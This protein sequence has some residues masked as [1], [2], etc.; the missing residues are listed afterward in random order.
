[1]AVL[2]IPWSDA[3][4]VVDGDRTYSFRQLREEAQAISIEAPMPL[5]ATNTIDSV[6]AI[7]AALE[8][9]VPIVMIHPRL[10]APERAALP[11]PGHLDREV[12]AVLY[13]SGTSGT[14]KGAI[15]TRDAF[16]AAA[17]ASEQVLGWREDDRWLLCMPLAHVGGLSIVIRCLLAR[18]PFVLGTVRELAKATIASLVPTQL[19][20]LLDDPAWRPPASLRLVLLGG[21]AA[22]DSLLAR[23]RDRGVPVRTTYGLT[24]ACSQV[25]TDGVPLPGTSVR[26]EDGEIQVCG[27][28]MMR[29]YL[30][31]PPLTGWFA[32]GDLGEFVD[33][34]L[35]VHA[36][37]SDLIVTGGE[38]VYPAEVE[39]ILES[40]PGVR[41]ALVYGIPDDTWGQ[42]VA[43]QIVGDAPDDAA[44]AANL[45]PHKRPRV[46]EIVS[47]IRT[48]PSGKKLRPR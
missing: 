44:L 32:T 33:G 48:T 24:E 26:I 43:A 19:A 42:I 38:N 16:G 45:A 1:V 23:A 20:R 2:T 41:A 6:I 11:R 31:E 40:L 10:T 25:A 8:R 29:G 46:I 27:P 47:E 39:A 18:K 3:I 28:T 14:P 22:P 34:K 4:A 7:Y 9:R 35:V 13:T 36:R 5:V 17:H 21:A 37:R 30:G 12:L 15:L